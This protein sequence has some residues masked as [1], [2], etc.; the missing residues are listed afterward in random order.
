MNTNHI[1]VIDS[2]CGSGKTSWAIDYINSLGEDQRVLYITPF[3]AECAR[4]QNAVHRKM[5]QPD[6][7]LGNG[8]KRNH[9]LDLI[10]RSANI[11][12]TH[13]LF[14]DVDDEII[15]ALRSSNYILILDEAF[16]VLD[17]F[18]MWEE[19]PRKTP[20][21]IKDTMTTNNVHALLDKGFIAVESDYRVRW[22]DNEHA[23]DKYSNLKRLADRGLIFLIRN[24]L[25]LWSF[26]YEIFMPGIFNEVYI[27]T[28]LFDSQMQKYY[29]DYFN[30]PYSKFHI[31]TINNKYTAIE[32]INSDYELQWK[33]DVKKL[34]S[35]CD[36]TRL[37]K[38]GD[39][40]ND[41]YGRNYS[42]ALSKTWYEKN[43]NEIVTIKNHII[44]YFQNISKSSTKER[45]WTCFEDDK[46]RFKDKNL[47]T[48]DKKYWVALNS[49][50]TNN[51][52][53]KST[54]AYPINRY[55]DPFYN[56]FF[57]IRNINMSQKGFAIAE[58]I[59][60]IWR[61]RIRNNQSVQIYLPSERMRT[62]LIDFL[63]NKPIIDN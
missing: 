25:L 35:I 27:L 55:C 31:E 60:W 61:S 49:R 3:L 17:K 5:Q 9:F 38:I 59:Q 43:V 8:R 34:I 6:A 56:A 58:F 48:S 7:R 22:I 46:K 51:F 40:Y 13:S 62:L 52:G 1:R 39:I 18:D 12:S 47:S 44:N 4:V 54:L 33:D 24:S 36:N 32:T 2:P 45:M 26:P 29:Y 19:L 50:S 41:V 14:A 53:Y 11:V 30:I 63:N 10:R 28:Y 16:E 21:E 23:L 42:S 57:E 37:N 20:D 15:E